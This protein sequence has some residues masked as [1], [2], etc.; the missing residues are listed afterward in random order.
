MLEKHLPGLEKDFLGAVTRCCTEVGLITLV[1]L[2]AVSD[3]ST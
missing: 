3:V 2:L 1:F